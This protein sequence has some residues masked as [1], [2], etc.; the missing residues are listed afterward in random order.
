MELY[1][2]RSFS[3]GANGTAASVAVMLLGMATVLIGLSRLRARAG[4]TPEGD[5]SVRRRPVR[6]R[7]PD[8]HLL[9]ALYP[10]WF[11]VRR[12]SR[13]TPTTSSIRPGFPVHPTFDFVCA[14]SSTSRCRAGCGT[15]SSSPS[16]VG[17]L[18]VVRAARG[19]R[20]RLRRASAARDLPLDE[21]RA[22]GGAAG[23]RCS[24]RCSSSWST[25]AWSTTCS[26]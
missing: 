24:C 22:D 19:L 26:R 21:R 16:S 17:G 25:P 3:N 8:H 4:R 2:W 18:D 13:R 5:R 12:R 14:L 10:L 20:R 1:I 6:T 7:V 15:A 9:A 23:R 11:I